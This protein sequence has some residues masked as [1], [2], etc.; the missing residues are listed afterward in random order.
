L[1]L[2]FQHHDRG[3]IKFQAGSEQPVTDLRIGQVDH[4]LGPALL[5]LRPTPSYDDSLL[6]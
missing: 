2:I 4:G 1:K 3:L 6:T 5:G